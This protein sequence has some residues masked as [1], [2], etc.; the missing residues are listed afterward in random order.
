ME[1]LEDGKVDGRLHKLPE[2]STEI[3]KNAERVKQWR[4]LN[5][6]HARK[7]NQRR[8]KR[9]KWEKRCGHKLKDLPIEYGVCDLCQS[10]IKLGYQQ[11][12]NHGSVCASCTQV[13]IHYGSD[14]ERMRAAAAYFNLVTENWSYDNENAKDRRYNRDDVT[15]K[16]L[17]GSRSSN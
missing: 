2:N 4:E 7:Y 11:P 1:T 16:F 15:G 3:N 6:K 10:R 14:P 8:T 5:K 17:P 9:L 12:F 13:F